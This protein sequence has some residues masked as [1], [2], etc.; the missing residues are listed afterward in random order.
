MSDGPVLVEVHIEIPVG[1]TL[2]NTYRNER[3]VTLQFWATPEAKDQIVTML[4]P[5]YE[6][7][8]KLKAKYE[9]IQYSETEDMGS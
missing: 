5:E 2:N 7:Y 3:G 9:K 8:L 6:T 1:A 4:M